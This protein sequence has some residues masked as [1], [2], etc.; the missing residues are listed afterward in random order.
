MQ[1]RVPEGTDLERTAAPTTPQF[2]NSSETQRGHEHLYLQIA[3]TNLRFARG[4][5]N[6]R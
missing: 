5:S 3:S 4:I 2:L 6:G 1:D